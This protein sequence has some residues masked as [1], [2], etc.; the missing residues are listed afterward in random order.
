MKMHQSA[1]QFDS[2]ADSFD[3][4]LVTEDYIVEYY[5]TQPAATQWV[6]VGLARQT[7]NTAQKDG[8]RRLVAGS[9]PTGPAAIQAMLGRCQHIH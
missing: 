1:S 8:G 5:L 4:R 2:R 9:G 7:S 3:T 6:A